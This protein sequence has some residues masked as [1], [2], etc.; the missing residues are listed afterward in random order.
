M[1]SLR[2]GARYGEVHPETEKYRIKCNS[3]GEY[4]LSKG[5]LEDY[6]DG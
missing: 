3:C 6:L 2:W 5:E 1:P 4:I